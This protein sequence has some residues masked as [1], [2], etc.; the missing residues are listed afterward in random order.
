M[1]AFY[2]FKRIIGPVGVPVK[3][4]REISTPLQNGL[5]L[6]GPDCSCWVLLH[7]THSDHK[8]RIAAYPIARYRK[9]PTFLEKYDVEF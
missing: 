1:D 3:P 2:F 6:L 7:Y 9:E 8:D 5:W 4:V